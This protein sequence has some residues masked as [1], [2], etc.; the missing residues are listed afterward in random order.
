MNIKASINGDKLMF[1]DFIVIK[2]SDNFYGVYE[3]YS[4]D[5]CGSIITSGT[6]SDNASK[7]AKLLQIGYNIAKGY[8]Y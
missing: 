7:K 3:R 8:N 1:N 6:T 2:E 5:K 4:D